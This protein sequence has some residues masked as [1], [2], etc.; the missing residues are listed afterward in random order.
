MLA[1]LR[2]RVYGPTQDLR[3]FTPFDITRVIVVD[4]VLHAL[5]MEVNWTVVINGRISSVIPMRQSALYR[6]RAEA[7][8]LSNVGDRFASRFSIVPCQ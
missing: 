3:Q 8:A 6:R 7:A 5:L 2:T 1:Y 4:Y